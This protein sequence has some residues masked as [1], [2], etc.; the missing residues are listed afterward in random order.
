MIRRTSRVREVNNVRVV[1]KAGQRS[2]QP[3]TS[4]WIGRSAEP[5]WSRGSRE[6]SRVRKVS[7]PRE[8]SRER[9]VSNANKAIWPG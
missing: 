4:V 8:V 7:R 5:S 3:G 2:A 1:G 6:V 9:D